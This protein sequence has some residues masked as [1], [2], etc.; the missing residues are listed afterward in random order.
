M[1]HNRFI[2]IPVPKIDNPSITVFSL[3]FINLA[4]NILSN[5]SFRVSALSETWRGMLTWQ[6]VGNLAGFI[7]VLT[8]TGLLRHMPLHIAFPMT[9]GLTILGVQLVAARWIFHEDISTPQWIG[10][11]FIVIGIWLIRS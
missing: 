7:T 3:I 9:M 11:I 1:F 2:N 4:F 8:L 10:S 6:V 5:A